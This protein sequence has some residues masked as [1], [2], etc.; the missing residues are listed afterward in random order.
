MY[1]HRHRLLDRS[2]GA[3]GRVLQELMHP[4]FAKHAAFSTNK[5]S[6]L[7]HD[8]A[9]CPDRSREGNDQTTEP[10]RAL[11]TFRCHGLTPP[12]NASLRW[13]VGFLE[14]QFA[15]GLAAFRVALCPKRSF[16]LETR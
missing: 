15:Q 12:P 14:F 5:R 1:T 10:Q 2:I 16:I 3:G 6:R 9:V 13:T 7:L 4:A 8:A 11:P